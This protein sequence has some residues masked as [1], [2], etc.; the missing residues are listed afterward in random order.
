M[1]GR[2]K[3]R[4]KREAAERAKRNEG[5][6]AS[7]DKAVNEATA[8]SQ[9]ACEQTASDKETHCPPS[10]SDLEFLVSDRCT[11]SH[12]ALATKE[13]PRPAMAPV[14]TD[15]Y[16]ELLEQLIAA[17]LVINLLLED[18]DKKISSVESLN[19]AQMALRV[20]EYFTACDAKLRS[21]TVPGLAYAIG[22]INRKQLLSFV[23]ENYDTLPGYIVARALMRIEEQRNVEI[24]SGGGMMTGHKIDLATNFDWS[25][26]KNNQSKKDDDK[27]QQNIT[28]NIINY[29]SLPPQ[30]MT[31]EEWQQR[32]LAEQKER[33]GQLPAPTPTPATPATP[34][35]DVGQEN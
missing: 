15:R 8:A 29:N 18:T 21:Y 4:A 19:A 20:K 16:N 2:P 30:S 1:A 33:Q 28:Q 23:S 24:L 3:T 35:I 5:I 11:L 17:Q 25:D 31:V 14:M 22:F 34:A 32:F 6:A 7:A 12:I 26:T 10:S 13:P 9:A 27:P